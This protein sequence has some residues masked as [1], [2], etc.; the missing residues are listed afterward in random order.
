MRSP[1]R[2]GEP[3]AASA[4]LPHAQVLLAGGLWGIIGLWNR[5][6]SAAGLDPKSI[7]L[8]RNFGGLL[9]LTILFL[10]MDRNIFRVKLRHL[11]LF[12][13]TGVI[14]ILLF[15]LCYFSCQQISSLAVSAILLYTAPTFVL[16][17]SALLFKDKLTKGRLAALAL[18]FLGCVFVSGV[19]GGE[20]S[21]SGYGLLLGLG[22]GFFY[23]LYS[24]FGRYALAHYEPYTV[25]FYTFLFAGVGALFVASPAELVTALSVPKT[26][27]LALCLVTISTVLPYL[28]YTKGLSKLD[29]GKASILASTEPVVA[30]FTGIL[31]FGEPLSLSV[32]L[33]LVCII[34][35]I[36]ILR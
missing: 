23:A 13:G 20:L 7:V 11:P 29:S 1:N 36:Y 2:A 10:C 25:T 24:I 30:A 22:A 27:L 35:S 14:S 4:Y 28:L 16:L 34:V 6:L 17:L 18:A 33:G 26:A 21:V 12:F 9:L 31:A 19:L 32:L 8:I 15:T 5:Q 3:S